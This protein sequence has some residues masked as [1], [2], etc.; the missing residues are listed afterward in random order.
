[1][2][3]GAKN[4]LNPFMRINSYPPPALSTATS[5]SLAGTTLNT[6][7]MQKTTVMSSQRFMGIIVSVSTSDPI[8]P[9]FLRGES[10]AVLGSHQSHLM[11]LTLVG[12]VQARMISRTPAILA[13]R[14][15]N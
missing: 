8:R 5:A 1:M 15:I 6:G 9:Y 3:E 2:Q 13:F 12:S 10:I 7:T 14:Y 4:A 11:V